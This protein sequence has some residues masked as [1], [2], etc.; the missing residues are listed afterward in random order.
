MDEALLKDKINIMG[1]CIFEAAQ[2]LW[3][4]LNSALFLAH[5]CAQNFIL[6]LR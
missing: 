2:I 5:L 3:I 1:G 6:F 4:I